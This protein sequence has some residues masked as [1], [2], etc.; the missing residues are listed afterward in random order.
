[1]P[2]STIMAIDFKGLCN[3]T[4]TPIKSCLRHWHSLRGGTYTQ[5]Y[6]KVKVFI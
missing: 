6:V 1:M 2:V 3:L 4:T 5:I